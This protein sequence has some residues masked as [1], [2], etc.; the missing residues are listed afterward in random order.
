MADSEPIQLGLTPEFTSEFGRFFAVWATAELT[1]D[2]A[3]GKFLAIPH[4]ETHLITAGTD[5]NRK[6]R[7]LQALAKRKN[8]PKAN[9]IVSS[10][11]TIQNESLRNTFSHSYYTGDDAT[12]EFIERSRHGNYDPKI[13]KFT[14]PEFE[15]HVEKLV[16]AGDLLLKAVGASRAEMQEF[17]DAASKA[18][19]SA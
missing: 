2:F 12:V 14:L 4:E 10:L 13:H 16:V 11:R 5:F 1:I 17:V 18:S 6:A 7:L 8:A 19:H 3:I 9:E 15:D